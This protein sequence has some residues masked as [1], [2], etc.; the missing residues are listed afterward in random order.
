MTPNVTSPL[1]EADPE[2]VD[3]IL[4]DELNALSFRDREALS[5]EVHGVRS[6]APDETPEMVRKA[7]SDLNEE[8][9]ERL[10]HALA[11]LPSRGLLKSNA[12]YNHASY[13]NDGNHVHYS[14]LSRQEY[15]SELLSASKILAISRDTNCP[16]SIVS[17]HASEQS[18]TTTT[19]FGEQTAKFQNGN[20]STTHN[21]RCDVNNGNNGN[22]NGAN[23]SRYLYALS[24]GF[25]VRFLRAELFDVKKA[26]A[27]Y[28]KAIDFLVAYFG[29]VALQRP[30]YIKDLDK[31]DQKLLRK[32]FVQF[33]PSRDRFGRRIIV[34]LDA[35]GSGYT[36]KNR[37]S[38]NRAQSILL[39]SR[40][41]FLDSNL[42]YFL[43]LVSSS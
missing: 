20:G 4:A 25:R 16:D 31:E 30:L 19:S 11:S 15:L 7:L 35:F 39:S 3:R 43:N 8:I 29:L 12:S 23:C 6:M 13:K 34:F 2:D 38:R 36:H 22:G 28:M 40:N 10:Y 24:D 14:D 41:L 42:N 17:N 1:L 27:R 33:M 21:S 37:V 5:E 9:E 32:G 18:T 26:A